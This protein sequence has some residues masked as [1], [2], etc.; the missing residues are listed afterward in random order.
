MEAANPSTAL[1]ER[2]AQ[3]RG[4]EMVASRSRSRQPGVSPAAGETLD[5][6]IQT[7]AAMPIHK[8][9]DLWRQTMGCESPSALTRDLLA[10]WLIHDLQEK[11]RG[12]LRPKY[13]RLLARIEKPGEE[14]VRH[15]KTGS[16]IVREY[17]GVVHEVLAV[18]DGFCWQGKTYSSLSTIARMITGTSWNGPRFFG[19]RGAKPPDGDIDG[20]VASKVD[21]PLAKTAVSATISENSSSLTTAE[22]VAPP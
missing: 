13:R 7:V 4:I 20:S 11:H 6:A 10:R 14:P 5:N 17:Q 1:T 15:I 19:L 22:Q 21:P 12:A 9:Q 16:V 2:T 18:P 8:L 3:P